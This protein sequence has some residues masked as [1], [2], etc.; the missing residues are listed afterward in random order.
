[1]GFA[2]GDDPLFDSYKQHVGPYHWTPWE[3]FAL[4]FP[5]VEVQPAD[6]TVVSWV[7]PQTTRTKVDNRRRDVY[8]A[9]RWARSRIYGEAFNSQLREHV[10]TKLTEIGHEAVAPYLSPHWESK[11]SEAFVYSSIW[12]ERHAAFASGLGTFGLC[13]GL[14]TPRGKAMRVGSVVTRAQIPATARPYEDHQAYCLFF[15]NGTCGDCIPRC[16]V[17]AINETGHDKEV[18]RAHL[19]TTEEYVKNEYGF[20]GYGCGLCQTGVP[21]ESGV[22]EELWQKVETGPGRA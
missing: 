6:L 1:V 16:P 7:L 15:A 21:C 8:P 22:P 2:R 17:G 4:S 20:E 18:C 3:I 5:G 19:S 11:S 14:I 9:E 10:A 13:D 12:S